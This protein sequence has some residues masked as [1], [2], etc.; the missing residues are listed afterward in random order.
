MTLEQEKCIPCHKG[1]PKMTKEQAQELMSEVP[2]WSLKDSS[3]ERTFTFADF[4]EAIEFV[5][6]VA[7]LAQSQDHHPDIHIYYNKVTL[8]LSTHKIGGLSRNDF[9]LAAQINGIQVAV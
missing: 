7:V 5:N 2:G 3:I 8:E 6:K 9:I 1:T 4:Y